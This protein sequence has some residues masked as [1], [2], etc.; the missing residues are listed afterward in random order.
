MICFGH[1]YSKLLLLLFNYFQA[2]PVLT[3]GA[4]LIIARPEGHLDPAYI[5]SLILEHHVTGF[6]CTVPTLAKE[7]V[8][9]LQRAGHAPYAPMRAWGIGGESA[10]ADVVRQMQT[11]FPNLRGPVNM[12]GPTEVTAV[13]VQHVFERGFANIVIGGP[14]PNTH[15]YIVD[16]GL[17]PVPVGVPGEL[18]LSGPRLA[19][20]Y[21]GRPDLTEE[22]FI[23]NPCFD[24]IREKVAPGLLPYCAKAYRTGDLV[25]WRSDGNIEFLGRIDRQVKITGVRIELGEVEGALES[26][27]GVT[28]AVAAAVAD[29]SGQKRLVGYVTPGEVDPAVVIAHCRSVL[30][31]AMVPSVVLALESFPL[32]PGGKID[33]KSLPAPDWSGGGEDEYVAPQNAI[34]E[35]LQLIWMDCLEFEDSISVTADYFAIGGTSLKTGIINAAIRQELDMKDIPGTLIN[36]NPT[37]RS[38]AIELQKLIAGTET[39]DPLLRSTTLL[40]RFSTI[41]RH[42]AG[43]T[44]IFERTSEMVHLSAESVRVAEVMAYPVPETRLPY[45]LYM[46]LQLILCAVAGTVVPASYICF[47]LAALLTWSVAGGFTLLLAGPLLFAGFLLSLAAALIF[48]KKALFPRGMRPGVYPLYGWV[49]CRWITYRALHTAVMGILL[50][51]IRRSKFM[52]IIFRLLGAQIG[53]VTHEIA[54]N[55]SINYYFI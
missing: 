30:V 10:P 18:L 49:Y 8:G 32:L 12:Y 40:Q 11:A 23:P 4:K 6:V 5:V 29:A 33:V 43:T 27:A 45:Q 14:D 48:G 3:A 42:Q 41:F 28:Q 17:R 55:A 20:G 36:N 25:R 24:L 7:Y 31:P 52:P 47:A 15:T 16:A 51:F 19:L 39:R 38:L 9:E 13:T 53:Y 54:L 44:R 2:L 46:L 37:I 35:F 26:A 1:H 21:A 50:R 34:E 22:K